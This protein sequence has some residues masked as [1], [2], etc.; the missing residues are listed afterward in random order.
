MYSCLKINRIFLSS[1]KDTSSIYKP[2]E[3]TRVF[4][5]HITFIYKIIRQWWLKKRKKFTLSWKWLWPVHLQWAW[6]EI[7]LKNNK[8]PK[9][10]E[11]SQ[12]L[13]KT[14]LLPFKNCPMNVLISLA[15]LTL[16]EVISIRII[17]MRV[18]SAIMNFY[19]SHSIAFQKL[20]NE[21]SYKFSWINSN[22]S[23]KH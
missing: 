18:I 23:Y 10:L 14:I 21:R 19:W 17:R 15:E 22:R 4:N 12:L 20:S 6:F 9:R 16:T 8:K 7:L 13:R 3:A 11:N 1:T 5:K 2:R